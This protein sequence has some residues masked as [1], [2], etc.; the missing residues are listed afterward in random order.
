MKAIN[1]TKLKVGD[2]IEQWVHFD[3]APP[4]MKMTG[5]VIW[6][7]PDLRFYRARFPLPNGTTIVE[8]YTFYGKQSGS[9]YTPQESH[10]HQKATIIEGSIKY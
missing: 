9:A 8:S 3:H 1:P 5:E 6:I 7:H 10:R 2:V 4:E